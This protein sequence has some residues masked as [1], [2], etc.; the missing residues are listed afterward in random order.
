MHLCTTH[1]IQ[2]GL[3]AVVIHYFYYYRSMILCDQF[4]SF[5]YAIK[6]D[7]RC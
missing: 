5:G 3:L 6:F 2:S 1:L 7:F 4:N